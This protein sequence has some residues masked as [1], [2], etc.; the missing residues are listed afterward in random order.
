MAVGAYA[1]VALAYVV[2]FRDFLRRSEWILAVTAGA[3]LA[4]SAVMDGLGIGTATWEESAKFLGIVGW[5]AFLV[6]AA[7]SRLAEPRTVGRSA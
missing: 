2:I 5:T 7:V 6:R 1:V 3:L 4:S